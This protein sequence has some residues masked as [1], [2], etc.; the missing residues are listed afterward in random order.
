MKKILISLMIIFATFTLTG[1]NKS[2]QEVKEKVDKMK[3]IIGTYTLI[4]VQKGSKTFTEEDIAAL[5]ISGYDIT[6]EFRD[7]KTGTINAIKE[8]SEFTYDSKYIIIDEEKIEYTYEND[9][10]Y[11]ERNNSIMTFKKVK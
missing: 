5:K 10:I 3:D 7:D 1:C 4:E 9:I 6:I 8:N 11:F 2:N